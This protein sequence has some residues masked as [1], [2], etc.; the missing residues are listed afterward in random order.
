MSLFEQRGWTTI[1]NDDLI[2]NV[3]TLS[4]L[5]L[6]FTCA[7]VGYTFALFFTSSLISSGITEPLTFCSLIGAG[8]GGI[9]GHTLVSL[10]HAGVA[11]IFVCVAEDPIALQKHHP[12]EFETLVHS[13]QMIHPGTLNINVNTYHHNTVSAPF[14]P[15]ANKV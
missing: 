11:S 10:L 12:N 9:V 6:S 8:V 3:L 2:S 14:L 15:N 4:I 13:W 5:A 7:A 1:I